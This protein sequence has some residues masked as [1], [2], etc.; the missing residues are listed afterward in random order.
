MEIVLFERRNL[1]LIS[2]MPEKDFSGF[3]KLAIKYDFNYI[4]RFNF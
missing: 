2:L 4:Q 3:E 1:A